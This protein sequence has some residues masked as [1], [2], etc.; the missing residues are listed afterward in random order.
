[1]ARKIPSNDLFT[2]QAY[3]HCLNRIKSIRIIRSIITLELL[4]SRILKLHDRAAMVHA[5]TAAQTMGLLRF[6]ALRTF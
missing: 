6:A 4:S 2:I 1:M 3:A 5:A